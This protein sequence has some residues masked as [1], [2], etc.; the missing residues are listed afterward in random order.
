MVHVVLTGFKP[1]KKLTT[2]SQLSAFVI[3][4]ICVASTLLNKSERGNIGRHSNES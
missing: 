3:C 1:K 2:S 4:D